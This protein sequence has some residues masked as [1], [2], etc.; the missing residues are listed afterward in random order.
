M[1]TEPSLQNDREPPP[2]LRDRV[3]KA[4]GWVTAGFVLDKVIAAVQL[5]ILARL[6]TPADFG[7]VAASAVVLLTLL[8][9]SE[10]GLEPALVTRDEVGERDLAVAWTLSL[11]RGTV[12]A[13][14]V[15]L[16]ADFV[17]AFFRTPELKYLL[18]VHA[19]VLIIQGVQ[20]PALALLLRNLDLKRR[21]QLDLTRRVIDAGATI[22]LAVWLRSVW[23]LLLGQI[24]G[25]IV[26][27]VL[28]YRLAPFHPRFSLHRTTLGYFFRYG[29]HLNLTSI[30]I[31]GVMSGGEIV[32]GRVL[33]MDALGFYQIALT[34]PALIGARAAYVMK[35]VS[36]PTYAILKTDPRGTVRAFAF[37]TGLVGLVLIP[38]AVGVA[39]AAPDLVRIVFGP[40]WLGA[41]E[42][43]QILCVYAVCA[44]L[45]GMM[46]S[47]HYGLDRPE[48][49]TRIWAFQFL[50]YGSLILP[51]TYRFGLPGAACS[52]ALS[53]IL[54]L[55]LHIRYTVGLIG[56]EAWTVFGTLT[57]V[58]VVI[59][60]LAGMLSLVINLP[61]IPEHAVVPM[62]GILIGIVLY[63]LY[64][65][66]IEYPRLAELW[67]NR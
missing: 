47:L 41:V 19:V 27:S 28:S 57:R 54:G 56:T 2:R 53:S 35:H 64:L 13:C 25:Q 23:A 44:G 40:Q 42:P 50:L 1:T 4:G 48:L 62:I 22:A 38:V 6:L 16:L 9:L 5:A 32:I 51:L 17:A 10:V 52:L 24:L 59:A 65:W 7:L 63:S 20:S 26:S 43:L 45:S 8:T 21:V 34:I 3:M 37:Q 46:A 15:W 55:V 29:K 39:L 49:Q 30:L 31:L 66:R 36:F 61:A 33:G 14:A 58:V 12:L 67:K 11:A 60:V 18:R